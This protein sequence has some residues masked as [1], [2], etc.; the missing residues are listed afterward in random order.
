MLSTHCFQ[1]DVIYFISLYILSRRS[2]DRNSECSCSLR[3]H[4][5]RILQPFLSAVTSSSHHLLVCSPPFEERCCHLPV[6][7]AADDS[8]QIW[9]RCPDD[10]SSL[11]SQDEKAERE[12]PVGAL[13]WHDRQKHTLCLVWGLPVWGWGDWVTAERCLP[14]G[15]LRRS[16]GS[17]AK[18]RWDF[19][20][21]VH[22]SPGSPLYPGRFSL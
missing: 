6:T 4:K 3:N 17:S 16:G 13:W 7:D 15:P 9:K 2:S 5:K 11:R 1:T 20:L 14:V 19:S 10:G 21:Q 22:L 8:V 18:P 12:E